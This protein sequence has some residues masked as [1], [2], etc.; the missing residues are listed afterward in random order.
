MHC[1]P[2][3]QT[4]TSHSGYRLSPWLPSAA[5]HDWHHEVTHECFGT[6]GLLDS[7]FGTNARFKARVAGELPVVVL[8]VDDLPS[9]TS[10]GSESDS[11]SSQSEAAA[12]KTHH[13]KAE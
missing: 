12:P 7:L 9:A 2:T 5:A 4:C 1:Q 8:G 10:A 13:Q 6:V 3:A 11:D